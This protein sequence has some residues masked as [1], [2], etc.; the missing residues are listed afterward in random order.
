MDGSGMFGV[1]GSRTDKPGIF[2]VYGSVMY[3][4]IMFG[5]NGSE[6]DGSGIFGSGMFGVDG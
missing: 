2:G 3:G 4:S 1:D 6:T 5:V